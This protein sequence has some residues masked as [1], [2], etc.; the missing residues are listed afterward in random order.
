MLA[1]AYEMV[2]DLYLQTRIDY[3]HLFYAA[4][5]RIA[6]VSMEK[7]VKYYEIVGKFMVVSQKL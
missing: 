6:R 7:N 5:L 3:S 2:G 1:F 4:S